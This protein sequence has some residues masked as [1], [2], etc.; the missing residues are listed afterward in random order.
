[1][2]YFV[3]MGLYHI[4]F[5]THSNDPFGEE[6]FYAQDDKLAIAHA[7]KR[8]SSPFGMGHEIWEQRRLVHREIYGKRG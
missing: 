3:F 1:V 4:R 7:R 6:R 8:L 2:A 5:L